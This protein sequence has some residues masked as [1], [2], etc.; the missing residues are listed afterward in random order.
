[1]QLR[2][3]P[4]AEREVRSVVI[5]GATGSIGKSTA[6]IIAGAGGAFRVEAIAGGRDPQALARLAR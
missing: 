1:M 6:E 4:A 5:L 3:R 2:K